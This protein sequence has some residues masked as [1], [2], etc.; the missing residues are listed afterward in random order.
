MN[1][2]EIYLN[3]FILIDTCRLPLTS[4]LNII[5]GE[6]GAGKSILLEAIMILLGKRLTKDHFNTPQKPC[7]I[8]GCL[9]LKPRSSK[10]QAAQEKL[11]ALGFCIEDGFVIRRTLDPSG[12]QKSFINEQH[13]S[14]Q[15]MTQIFSSLIEI[16][17][18]HEYHG[19]LRAD[20]H[21]SMVDEGLGET[22][23]HLSAY[24]ESYAL[25]KKL[26][27]E[28]KTLEEE[29][30]E[31]KS[32]SD[33]LMFQQDFFQNKR[34]S[35][36]SE[37]VELEDRIQVVQQSDKLRNTLEKMRHQLED[38]HQGILQG[39]AQCQ[40]WLK[41]FNASPPKQEEWGQTLLEI[42]EKTQ[43]FADDLQH[44]LKNFQQKSSEDIDA[45]NER[46]FFLQTLKSK[47]GPTLDEV[48][49]FIE[50]V[51]KQVESASELKEKKMALLKKIS[52]QKK[53]LTKLGKTLHEIRVTRANDLQQKMN[54]IL[55]D[56]GVSYPQFEVRF[57]AMEDFPHSRGTHDA[58]FYM[59]FNQGKASAPVR[60][61]ASG[62]ELSRMMLAFRSVNTPHSD[63]GIYLFDEVDAGV[64]GKTAQKIGAYLRNI[65]HPSSEKSHPQKSQVICITH[66][67]QIAAF[68]DHHIL[69]S[70]KNIKNQ[71]QVTIK[72]LLSEHDKIQ[73]LVRMIGGDLSNKH[74]VLTVKK[75]RKESESPQTPI[76]P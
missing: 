19:L 66:L 17:G 29:D 10:D 76:H 53:H 23:K 52:T 60:K 69:V 5:S 16:C 9:E 34:P 75:M 30:R 68:A 67:P 44:H 54:H 40:K 45:L 14:T 28:I 57:Q 22:K 33:Y 37:D 72:P 51:E 18:Q 36:T 1:L 27:I 7:V 2:T 43:T 50:S 71:T 63:V 41:G 32:K 4:G 46:L 47:Y 73:E 74:A 49:Q 59:S 20:V 31:W 13:I 55:K 65:A 61:I 42:T 6:T 15:A 38:S 35:S 64:G 39:L 21:M 70:K 56:L 11:K 12:R 3:N 8:E 58:E 26:D 48:C 62:G 25:Y 24:H